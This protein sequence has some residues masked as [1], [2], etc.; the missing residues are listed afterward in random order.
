LGLAVVSTVSTVEHS[1][2]RCLRVFTDVRVTGRNEDLG[3]EIRNVE[4][5]R[6]K[7]HV[8]LYIYCSSRVRDGAGQM[9]QWSGPQLRPG[10]V[11]YL[12]IWKGGRPKYIFLGRRP[13]PQ[14]PVRKMLTFF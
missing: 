5:V 4:V 10:P 13:T 9:V 12:E 14:I 2:K 1:Y 6:D 11:A 8:W 7:I 3:A